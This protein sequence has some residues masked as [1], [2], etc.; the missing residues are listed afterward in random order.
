MERKE[1]FS[2]I[3]VN[4]KVHPL[5]VLENKYTK[6]VMMNIVVIVLFLVWTCNAIAKTENGIKRTWNVM[7]RTRDGVWK[8]GCSIMIKGKLLGK[9]LGKFRYL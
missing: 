4:L 9:K 8:R 5:S 6:M 3:M 2:T 7:K 1:T